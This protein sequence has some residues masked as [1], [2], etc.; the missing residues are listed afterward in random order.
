[1]NFKQQAQRATK[2]A[3]RGIRYNFSDTKENFELSRY[4]DPPPTIYASYFRQHIRCHP[5]FKK[6]EAVPS[7]EL[8]VFVGRHFASQV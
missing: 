6:F 4:G 8:H 1:M 3:A 5:M 2:L 7:C